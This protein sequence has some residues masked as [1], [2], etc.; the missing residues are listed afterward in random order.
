MHPCYVKKQMLSFL[1]SFNQEQM[2]IRTLYFTLPLFP[3]LCL[4]H[5]PEFMPA[6]VSVPVS[7]CSL[8]CMKGDM[9]V[10]K[11]QECFCSVCIEW[12]RMGYFTEILNRVL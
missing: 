9:C 1:E 3:V 7:A 5:E 10:F 2:Q 12:H 8:C 6:S 4:L 11:R